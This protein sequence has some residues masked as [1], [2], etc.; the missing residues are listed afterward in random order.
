[1]GKTN[2]IHIITI[3]HKRKIPLTFSIK[4]KRKKTWLWIR[5]KNASDKASLTKAKPAT[6]IS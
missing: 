4:N 5:H 3:K 1:M 6:G 2:S